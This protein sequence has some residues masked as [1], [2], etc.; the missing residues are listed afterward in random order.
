MRFFQ[1]GFTDDYRLFNP[2]EPAEQHWLGCAASLWAARCQ[3]GAPGER[4]A[5]LFSGDDATR[6]NPPFVSL[7]FAE[8]ELHPPSLR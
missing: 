5:S 8:G 3:A 6:R 1:R 4:E 7:M 2:G